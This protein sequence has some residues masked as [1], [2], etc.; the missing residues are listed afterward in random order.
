[1]IDKVDAWIHSATGRVGRVTALVAALLALASTIV[2]AY[3]LVAGVSQ[4]QIGIQVPLGPRL[5]LSTAGEEQKEPKSEDTEHKYPAAAQA[6]KVSPMGPVE[7]CLFGQL[8]TV[9]VYPRGPVRF[10]VRQGAGEATGTSN[11][12]GKHGVAPG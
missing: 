5:M 3:S 10:R 1:M 4:G 6:I 8:G 7:M 12:T 11:A 2:L 9:I